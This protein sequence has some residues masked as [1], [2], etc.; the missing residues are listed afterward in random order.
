[1]ADPLFR[2]PPPPAMNAAARYAANVEAIRIVLQLQREQRPATEAERRALALYSGWGDT[3]VRKRGMTWGGQL[4]NELAAVGLGD[5]ARRGIERST[6][7]AHF[8]A[9]DV[10]DAMWRIALRLGFA[11]LVDPWVLEPSCGAGVFFGLMPELP[12]L[13][14]AHV[15]GV[16]LDPTT[17]AIAQ[18]LYPQCRIACAGFERADLPEAAFDLVIGNVP[19]GDYPVD[20]E[21]IPRRLRRTIHDY[22]LCRSVTLLR[23]GGV[24]QLITSKGTLDK[25]GCSVR[26]WLADHVDLLGA[27]R[28]P[29]TAFE[30]NAGTQVTTDILILRRLDVE[31][32]G[33][34]VDWLNVAPVSYRDDRWQLDREAP[35]NLY[36]HAHPANVLGEW[37]A[38]KL[39]YGRNAA[40]VRP[41]PDE[42]RSIGEQIDEVAARLPAGA[43]RMRAPTAEAR[44]IAVEI[45]A[46][47]PR[48]RNAD[49]L[50]A[51]RVVRALRRVL[52]EQVEGDDASLDRARRV[53]NVEYD[54]L[55]RK[56]GPVRSAEHMRHHALHAATREPWWPM[57]AALEDDRGGKAAIFRERTV[58]RQE[59]RDARDPIDALYL[60]LD[61]AGRVDLDRVA[62]RCGMSR[63]DVETA[64]RGVVF[65]EGPQGEWVTAQAYLAGHVREKL[66]QA[67]IWADLDPD[68]FRANVEALETAQPEPIPVDQIGVTLGAGWVPADVYVDFLRHLFPRFDGY[69]AALTWVEQTSTWLLEVTS[70]ALLGS[71]ENTERYGTGR[72]DGVEILRHGLQLKSPVVYDEEEDPETG[73]TKRY[74]NERET[75]LAQAKLGD[76]KVK[77][78]AWITFDETRARR[79]AELYNERFNGFRR[80]RYDGAHLRFPGLAS[81]YEGAALAPRK[82]QVNGALRIV[83]R[84]EVD[85]SA[86]L[87]YRV[88]WGKTL[89]ALLGIVKR[90]QL[91]MSSKACV[92][93]P[94]HVL[95]QWQTAFLAFYPG[96]ADWLLAAADDSFD[97]RNRRRFLARAATSGAR[98][99]LL[100]YEQFKSI[101]VEPDTFT[102]YMQREVDELDAALQDA[103]EDSAEAKHLERTLKA[104]RKTLERFEVKQKDKWRKASAGADAPITWERLGFDLLAFDEAHYLKNDI[105]NTRMTNVAGLPRSESQRAFDARVKAHYLIAR[106]LFPG[107]AIDRPDGKLIGLTGT[108][109]TNTIAEAWV[110]MRLFQPRLLRRMGFWNFDAWAGVFTQ[111]VQSV[112]MDAVGKFRTQTRL[113]FQNVPELLDMLA[114]AWDTAPDCP[115]M[116]RP[117]L[118][119]GRMEVIETVGSAELKAYTEELAERA[120]EVRAG[121]V[122]PDV[123]NMLKITHDGREASL[124]NG[125]PQTDGWPIDRVTKVD[126]L[127]ARV[128]DLYV[129]SDAA[130][131]VQLIFCDLHTPRADSDEVILDERERWLQHGVYGVIVDRLVRAGVL[132][133]EVAYIHDAATDDE[134]RALFRRVN[135]GEIRV[136]IGS[137]QKLGTGVNVQRRALATH[138]VTVPWRPDWLEQADGRARRPGNTWEAVHSIAYPTT[139]SFDVVLWQMIQQ[140]AEM[141]AQIADGTYSNRTADDVGDMVL[142]A[143]VCRAIALGDVRVLDKVKMEIDLGGLQRSYKLWRADRSRYEWERSR[144]PREIEEADREV[145]DVEKAI[146]LRDANPLPPGAFLVKLRMAMGDD[147]QTLD[148]RAVADRRIVV[149]AESLLRMGGDERLIG[150]YRGFNL[151]LQACGGSWSLVVRDGGGEHDAGGHEFEVTRGEWSAAFATIE[152]R[153]AELE[154]AAFR[155]RTNARAKRQRLADLGAAAPT[156]RDLDRARALLTRYTSLCE[157]LAQNGIVDAQTFAFE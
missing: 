149:L 93:V 64:L 17:A 51:E 92:V 81:V 36:F 155:L 42:T 10:A 16:E 117:D 85:E 52:R 128:W 135:R 95:A 140:K 4:I 41:R 121:R 30:A 8:T 56:I 72:M 65:R 53:L 132:S 57:L 107:L 39:A 83:E 50:H 60:I 79:L 14:P 109:L 15:Y 90:L 112:E 12:T 145:A 82:H 88:G 127:A 84:G 46:E 116:T 18:S 139:G 34:E 94:K 32:P 62:A 108:P 80:R 96:C 11:D 138:H 25:E 71:S 7:N 59:Q 66:R 61:E 157:D 98:V 134:K 29:C 129:H 101:P 40:A 125:P 131:G 122:T 105:V 102:A 55:R 47:T 104:R 141:I 5:V 91:G 67:R 43:L 97:P 27:I 123:D 70:S 31:Q 6:V 133:V 119:G 110:L 144:L 13:D 120:A 63:P 153:L 100:T 26:R 86:L 99:V 22:F 126:A 2:L 150:N 3:E 44:P 113:K 115:D 74:R 9:H 73:A 156:W 69:G 76:V 77:W 19:F 38:D 48:H 124:F 68:A 143:S 78:A 106:E 75:M 37:C 33:R 23:P 137:T 58:A 142:S 130:A 49:E 148:D 45:E 21:R 35:V 147:W 87:T 111:Q 151:V 89:A 118:V 114:M 28:L 146:R 54:A 103:A 136:L 1:M 24:A 20:D 152:H 154:T